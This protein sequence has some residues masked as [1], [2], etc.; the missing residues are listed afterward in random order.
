MKSGELSAAYSVS[1]IA[2]LAVTNGCTEIV[3][4]IPPRLISEL[5]DKDLPC[6]YEEP[7]IISVATRNALEEIDDLVAE[8][9]TLK[10]Q[11]ASLEKSSALANT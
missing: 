5:S 10:A 3:M 4:G 1:D 2:A 8:L 9:D 11:V 6:V 7:D